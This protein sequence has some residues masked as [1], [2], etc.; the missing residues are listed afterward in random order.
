MKKVQYNSFM[1]HE[2]VFQTVLTQLRYNYSGQIF[3]STISVSDI[4]I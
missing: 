3:S 4:G 1:F 2:F